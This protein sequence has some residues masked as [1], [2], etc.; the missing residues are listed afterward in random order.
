[1]RRYRPPTDVP[2]LAEQVLVK[3]GAFR[4]TAHEAVKIA[5]VANSVSVT[6]EAEGSLA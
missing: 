6:L 3:A 1:M 2:A 5:A 4:D